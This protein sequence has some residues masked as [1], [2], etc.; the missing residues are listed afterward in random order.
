MIGGRKGGFFLRADQYDERVST[1]PMSKALCTTHTHT[2]PGP[3]RSNLANYKNLVNEEW[4][5]P[6][7]DNHI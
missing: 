6:S 3:C 5:R 4:Q 7:D 1:S 2:V